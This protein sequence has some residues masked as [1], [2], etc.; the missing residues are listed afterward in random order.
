V[1]GK[2]SAKAD[3]AL[4]DRGRWSLT[5]ASDDKQDPKR[6][7]SDALASVRPDCHPVSRTHVARFRAHV[8]LQIV[9]KTRKA[10]LKI[11]P[12]K[13]HST[14]LRVAGSYLVKFQL[15]RHSVDRA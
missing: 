7:S 12:P 8:R 6:Q 14:P 9:A 15:R 13:Q 5:A 4:V 10:I 2:A 1:K 3:G 11:E